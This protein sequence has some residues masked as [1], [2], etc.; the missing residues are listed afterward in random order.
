MKITSVESEDTPNPL[1][2]GDAHESGVSKVHRQITIRSHQF[3]HSP[4]IAAFKI[5]EFDGPGLDHPPEC[6]LRLPG[7][8]QKIHRFRQNRPGRPER[9]VDGQK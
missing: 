5:H 3:F 2:F 8:I 9:L 7:E 6:I 1:A 4:N